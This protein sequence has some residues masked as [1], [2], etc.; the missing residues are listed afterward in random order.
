[1]TRRLVGAAQDAHGNSVE[2]SELE[3]IAASHGLQPVAG[4]T[5]SNCD[6]LVAGESASSSGKAK[7]SRDYGIPVMSVSEFLENLAG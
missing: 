2:R 1:M 4:V 7:K 3:E 6:L 5:K